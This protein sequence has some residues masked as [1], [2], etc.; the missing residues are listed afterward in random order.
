M[1]FATVVKEADQE[2]E[3][4][5][6]N[7]RD[8]GKKNNHGLCTS[9]GIKTPNDDD[10]DD[11]KRFQ[12]R[13]FP[14][15][16]SSDIFF[17]DLPP[18][19]VVSSGNVSVQKNLHPSAGIETRNADEK[20]SE[21]RH[22]DSPPEDCMQLEDTASGNEQQFERRH[23]DLPPEDCMQLE[24]TPCG[25]DQVDSAG[26]SETTDE[27][28][29]DQ[30]PTQRRHFHDKTSSN[31]FFCGLPQEDVESRSPSDFRKRKG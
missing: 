22:F 9:A 17:C 23:F 25:D 30:K 12:R 11:Q 28:D 18:E 10:E 4:A 5:I 24:N 15:K 2:P 6:Q 14:Y 29:A 1:S 19:H 7:G 16:M 20:Q 26:T 31:I 27:D 21:R 13:H 8:E 3:M